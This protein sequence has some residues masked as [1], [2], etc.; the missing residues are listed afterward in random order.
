MHSVNLVVPT[1]VTYRDDAKLVDYGIGTPNL[2]IFDDFNPTFIHQYVTHLFATD[3]LKACIT[4]WVEI[5]DNQYLARLYLI[6]QKKS[7]R[8]VPFTEENIHHIYQITHG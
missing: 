3:V 2:F 1:K 4:G 7:E 8:A 5:I 6:E